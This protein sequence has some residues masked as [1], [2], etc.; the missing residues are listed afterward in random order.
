LAIAEIIKELEA[1]RDRLST[2][3]SVLRGSRNGTNEPGKSVRYRSLSHAARQRISAAMKKKWA[4]RKK[5]NFVTIDSIEEFERDRDWFAVDPDGMIGQFTTAGMRPLA[6]TVKQDRMRQCGLIARL[7]KRD[8]RAT[9]AGG[10]LKGRSGRAVAPVSSTF[11]GC[12]HDPWTN[13][14]SS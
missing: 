3:I 11:L 7:Y 4:E 8:H 1:Q 12:I 14:P 2:A 13:G 6:K 9:A 5:S 10:G